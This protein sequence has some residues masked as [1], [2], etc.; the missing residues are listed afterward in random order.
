[1]HIAIQGI[2]GSF[3]QIAAF[4]YFGERETFMPICCDSFPILFRELQE[5]QN[6][7]PKLE[8][9]A[10][11]IFNQVNR[12]LRTRHVLLV[13]YLKKNHKI[14]VVDV[15]PKYDEF[16][17]KKYKPEKKI[18]YLSDYLTLD[19]KKIYCAA[20]VNST[21]SNGSSNA[22]NKTQGSSLTHLPSCTAFA[23]P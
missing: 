12:N 15:V 4:K 19:T 18:L 1:M 2:E 3:H 22:I 7:F 9:Y 23:G 14:E 5:N 20:P 8:E 6:Y 21:A 10:N 17:L 11:K 13:E 16:Y